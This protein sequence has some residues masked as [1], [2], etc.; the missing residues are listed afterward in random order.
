MAATAVTSLSLEPPSV[1]ACVNRSSEF[2]GHL[3]Q[4]EAFCINIL[5]ESQAEQSRVFGSR[6]H[7]H[8]RFKTGTWNDHPDGPPMLADAQASLICVCDGTF[9]YGSHA[10]VVGRVQQVVLGGAT[11]PLIYLDRKV[12]SATAAPAER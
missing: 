1:L 4:A 7:R 10:I 3:E 5:S 2:Y 12:I 6:H 9:K 11:A 8:E